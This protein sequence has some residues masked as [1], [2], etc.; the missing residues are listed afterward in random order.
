MEVLNEVWEARREAIT[1]TFEALE[2]LKRLRIAL[3]TAAKLEAKIVM[4]KTRAHMLT[5]HLF[6]TS[7][8]ALHKV[9][10]AA[11]L[12]MSNSS[13]EDI[14]QA[15]QRADKRATTRRHPRL[16]RQS[17]KV[18]EKTMPLSKCEGPEDLYLLI[19][20]VVRALARLQLITECAKDHVTMA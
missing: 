1:K 6:E 19:S 20:R 14:V 11:R 4:A 7:S 2:A 16:L 3:D 9:E 12:L 10:E 8:Q 13:V 18:S 5:Q 17:S 15:T